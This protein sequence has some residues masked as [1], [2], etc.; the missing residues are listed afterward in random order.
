MPI[1]LKKLGERVVIAAA[2]C[3]E[4]TMS[5]RRVEFRNGTHAIA[6]VAIKKISGVGGPRSRC[7]PGQEGLL[8][9]DRGVDV[10]ND[11]RPEAGTGPAHS[12]GAEYQPQHL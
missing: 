7:F 11:A 9:S 6:F 8:G 4:P 3:I 5:A 2:S 10:S 12:G 1:W